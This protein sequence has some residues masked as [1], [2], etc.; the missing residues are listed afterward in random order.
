MADE[1]QK[2]PNEINPETGQFDARFMLW[3]VFCAENGIAVET[4]P[5][6]LKGE[7]RDR[8][9]KLKNER[10]HRPTEEKE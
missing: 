9:D 8:W 4:L 1:K 2:L 10:L 5:S 6:D 3:R 7:V